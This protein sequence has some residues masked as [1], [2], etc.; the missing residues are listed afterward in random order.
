MQREMTRLAPVPPNL[1]VGR[2]IRVMAEITSV[3]IPDFPREN[4]WEVE[5]P[6][7]LKERLDD[8]DLRE[9][10]AFDYLVLDEAQDILARP[11]LWQCLTRFL[12]DESDCGAFALFGD[13]DYQVLGARQE[14]RNT[15]AGIE[16]TFHPVRWRLTENCR[17]YKI[18]AKTALGLSDLPSSVYSSYLRTGG[19]HHNYDIS[20]YKNSGQQ[21]QVLAEWIR[22]FIKHGYKPGEISI[23]S[24]LSGDK[25]IALELKDLGIEVR[26]AWCTGECVGYTSIHAFNQRNGK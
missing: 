13:F 23:L 25:C 26:P 11:R 18:V 6:E 1:V 14:M 15:M 21:V 2:A 9:V 3:V 22:E 10:A 8:A 24:F 16:K 12:R 4:Y 5:L 20:F 7:L 17:N 19:G